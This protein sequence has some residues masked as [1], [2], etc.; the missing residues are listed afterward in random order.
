MK[1]FTKGLPKKF[2]DFAHKRQVKHA[3][4]LLEPSIPF[5]TLVRRVDSEDIADEKIDL[6]L[7][8]NKVSLEDE[9][10]TK[11]SEHEEHIMV[12]QSGDPNNKSKPALKNN[13][14]TVTNLTM[15]F[16]IVIKNNV[17]MNT[18]EIKI[19]DQELLNNP[20]Y[21][22]FVV[23]P[24]IHKKL[25]MK[26]QIPFLLI[27]MIVINITKIIRM[28][29][30]EITIDTAVTVENIPKIIIDLIL[31]KDITIHLEV[32]IDLDTKYITNGELHLDLH[33]DLHTE[34]TLIIDT[35]LDLDTD[36]VL[37]HREIPLDDTI[38]HIYLHLD[39]EILNHDLEHK[40]DN[41]IE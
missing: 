4:T 19:K 35:I 14:H 36:L 21:S 31:D 32:H 7:E 29:D 30:T 2:K 39:Q 33:I 18:K 3:S 11:L 26:T 1:S 9:T 12:T 27:T 16:Q 24:I 34:I 38:T 23:N 17:M 8:I 37:N 6:A 13:V 41:K 25:K 5:H 22:T 28:I 40:T 20:L 15:V 10:N